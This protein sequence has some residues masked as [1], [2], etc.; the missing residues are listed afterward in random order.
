MS[1]LYNLTQQI[2]ILAQEKAKKHGLEL[3]IEGNWFLHP[4]TGPFLSTEKMEP[5]Q[6]KDWQEFM[7]ECLLAIQADQIRQILVVFKDV[8]GKTQ[9]LSLT[10]KSRVKALDDKWLGASEDEQG[11]YQLPLFTQEPETVLTELLEIL[12]SI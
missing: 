11:N 5:L 7:D 6:P 4:R 2:H 8:L 1:N 10:P 9:K 3:V 12:K